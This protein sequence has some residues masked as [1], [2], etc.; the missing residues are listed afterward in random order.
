[1][2]DLYQDDD[3]KEWKIINQITTERLKR[4]QEANMSHIEQDASHHNF[5]HE[6]DKN[7]AQDHKVGIAQQF[8]GNFSSCDFNEMLAKGADENVYGRYKDI[9]KLGN[10]IDF[11]SKA[12]YHSSSTYQTAGQPVAMEDSVPRTHGDT[13]KPQLM[14]GGVL[15]IPERK[16]DFV[17]QNGLD[18]ESDY[19]DEPPAE[20]DINVNKGV[21]MA[22]AASYQHKDDEEEKTGAGDDGNERL[23]MGT[24]REFKT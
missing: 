8:R 3:F 12:V 18:E 7:C 22:S 4:L 17:Q 16:E 19:D 13:N 6:M 24:V 11:G 10:D 15:Q 2:D 9:E 23:R 20:T 5:G 14:E 1:M 21:S